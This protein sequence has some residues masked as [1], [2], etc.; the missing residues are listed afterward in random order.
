VSIEL[1][2]KLVAKWLNKERVSNRFIRVDSLISKLSLELE[3][4][5]QLYEYLDFGVYAAREKGKSFSII[6]SLS[7]KQDV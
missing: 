2:A 1:T 6:Y 3:D 7:R 5:H 4:T